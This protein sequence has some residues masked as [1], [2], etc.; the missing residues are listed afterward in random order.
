MR[1]G[2]LQ[3]WPELDVGP[4][5]PWLLGEQRMPSHLELVFWDAEDPDPRA[6]RAYHELDFEWCYLWHALTEFAR[7]DYPANPLWRTM[8][9]LF[10]YATTGEDSYNQL[11]NF[12]LFTY[13]FDEVAG[14]G[15]SSGGTSS[16]ATASS[17]GT[18]GTS[19]AGSSQQGSQV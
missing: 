14:R 1:L 2:A 7:A 5:A 18:S 15:S 17:P 11:F 10:E 19:A 3:F 12:A 16:T 8:G 6:P 4:A 13:A 9:R